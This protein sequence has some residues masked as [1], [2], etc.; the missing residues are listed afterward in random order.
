MA[1]EAH[2]SKQGAMNTVQSVIKNASDENFERKKAKDGSDY[3]VLKAANG[4][5]LGRSEMYGSKAGME[6]GIKSVI[7]NAK[8]QVIKD[9]TV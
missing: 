7:K 6:N 5:A 9:L 1:G 2:S 4:E 8:E 3:F